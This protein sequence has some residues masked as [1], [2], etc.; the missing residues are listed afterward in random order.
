MKGLLR[1]AKG[2]KMGITNFFS[3]LQPPP[4]KCLSHHLTFKE[5]DRIGI[6]CKMGKHKARQLIHQKLFHDFHGE[7]LPL[8]QLLGS[9]DL[10]VFYRILKRTKSVYRERI[11]CLNFTQLMISPEIFYKI[12]PLCPK[13][14]RLQFNKDDQLSLDLLNRILSLKT[15]T[16]LEVPG[17]AMDLFPEEERHQIYG[18]SLFPKDDRELNDLINQLKTDFLQI[19]TL[20]IV[21]NRITRLPRLPG[22]ITHL[23]CSDCSIQKLTSLPRHLEYFDGRNCPL[24]ELPKCPPSLKTI[25]L[26][27]CPIKRLPEVANDCSILI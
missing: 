21:S 10:S 13:I 1:W 22:S 26:Q 14:M 7:A 5:I 25:L 2:G 12:L 19:T 24:T 6:T 17:S 18:A 9:D 8:N 15:I 11:A 3:T 4:L 16:R 27:G 20:R 23:T